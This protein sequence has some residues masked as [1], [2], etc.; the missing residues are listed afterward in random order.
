MMFSKHQF[1]FFFND[2]TS[3][4]IITLVERVTKVLD[5]GKYMVGV[6]FLP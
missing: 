4:V 5:T 2:S 3:H 1:V 6:L